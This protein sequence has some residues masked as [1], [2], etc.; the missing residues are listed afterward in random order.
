MIR[1]TLLAI[2]SIRLIFLAHGAVM[3]Q[4]PAM[5]RRSGNDV[6][7][8]TD[9]VSYV[10]YCISNDASDIIQFDSLPEVTKTE[11]A[12]YEPPLEYHTPGGTT[13]TSAY[14]DIT[15]HPGKNVALFFR[16]ANAII[17]ASTNCAKLHLYFGCN[18]NQ[19]SAKSRCSRQSQAQDRSVGLLGSTPIPSREFTFTPKLLHTEKPS[20]ERPVYSQ[21]TSANVTLPF[22]AEHQLGASIVQTTTS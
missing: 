6:I 21:M 16:A 14:I 7:L 19:R 20:V 11:P 1:S 18:V 17:R 3:E 4:S 5:P 8:Q 12:R 10:L 13:N 2:V 9:N 15:P 22:A